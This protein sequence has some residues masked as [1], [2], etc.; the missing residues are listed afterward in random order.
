MKDIEKLNLIDKN[1]SL[2]PSS[3]GI[4]KGSADCWERK[5]IVVFLGHA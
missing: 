3:H 4:R 5:H 1:I 2:F